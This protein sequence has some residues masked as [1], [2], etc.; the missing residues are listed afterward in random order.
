MLDRYQAMMHLSRQMLE[1]AHLAE[2][3]LL[4]EL[5]QQR[6]A[7]EA[8]LRVRQ[9]GAAHA[10]IDAKQERELVAV[11]LAANDQIELMVAIHLASLASP[12]DGAAPD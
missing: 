7:V 5:G 11:L 3:A 9:D 6:D 4:V 1:A 10:E 8:Q 2:W 12:D